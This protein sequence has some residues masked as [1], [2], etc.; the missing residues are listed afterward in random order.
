M[1][2][3]GK[4]GATGRRTV[5]RAQVPI[6]ATVS[7]SVGEQ[8]AVLIDISRTGARLG[9]A[10]LPAVGEQLTFQAAGVEAHG[11]V[12]WQDEEIGETQHGQRKRRNGRRPSP[13]DRS[14]NQLS[15]DDD[16]PGE[17]E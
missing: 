17:R 8:R 9:G 10:N 12:V 5:P 14:R 13:C 6:V 11:D 16:A 7:S 3:F 2:I 4:S 15:R 1:R